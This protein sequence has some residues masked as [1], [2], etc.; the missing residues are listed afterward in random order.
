MQLK[1]VTNS[2][3]TTAL[4]VLGTQLWAP[5]G[6]VI[7]RRCPLPPTAPLRA[8]LPSTAP[9]P[10]LSPPPLAVPYLQHSFGMVRYGAPARKGALPDDAAL[11]SDAQLMFALERTDC[12][13]TTLPF[14][15]FNVGSFQSSPGSFQSS[16]PAIMRH[17]YN[18]LLILIW[19]VGS[20]LLAFIFT[21]CREKH[22]T[23]RRL[24]WV[25]PS[26]RKLRV[27]THLATE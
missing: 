15:W 17:L 22:N 24:A 9:R 18:V 3:Q 16:P 8:P 5:Q 12:C 20:V 13:Y 1:M 6:S 7:A 19:C 23:R 14:G 25:L 27:H 26:V 2:K 10:L 4:Q 11:W 21:S